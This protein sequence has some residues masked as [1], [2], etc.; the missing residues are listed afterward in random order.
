MCAVDSA[1]YAVRVR[2]NFETEV[3]LMLRGHGY[4]EF[5]PTCKKKT[6]DESKS[7]DS[8]LFPGYLFCRLDITKR[9][10]VLKMPGVVSF[11]G[12][13]KVPVPVS[14][15]EIDSVRAMARSKLAM[16]PWPYLEVGQKVLIGQ[17]PLAG[18]EA[19]LLE[20]KGVYR[21]VVSIDLLRRSVIAEIN[22]SWITPVTSRPSVRHTST[23][24]RAYLYS[25][26]AAQSL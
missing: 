19:I 26:D 13:G 6:R 4:E 12:L 23:L 21:V 1:W 25:P 2:S 9:L 15:E 16:S 11:I 20:N 7:F 24:S 3:S 17:G 22:A 18:I 10:P 8:P 14:T 5:L